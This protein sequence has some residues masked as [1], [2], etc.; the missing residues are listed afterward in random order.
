MLLEKE[1]YPK[2]VYER[3][4][5]ST[6]QEKSNVYVFKLHT[7]HA[8]YFQKKLY[9]ISSLNFFNHNCFFSERD[10]IKTKREK[11]RAKEREEESVR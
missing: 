10:I 3:T 4:G 8:T 6:F 1:I 11:E 5:D 7:R 9:L 2:S